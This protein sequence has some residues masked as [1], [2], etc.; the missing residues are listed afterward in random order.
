MTAGCIF[1]NSSAENDEDFRPH[2]CVAVA[3]AV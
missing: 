3:I 2:R 1:N